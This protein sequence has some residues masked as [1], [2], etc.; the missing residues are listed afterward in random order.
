MDQNNESQ[1]FFER[2]GEYY[3]ASGAPVLQELERRV[4]GVAYGGNSYTTAEQAN[5]LV[6]L[7]NLR[8]GVQLLDVGSGAGWPGTFLAH[9][10]GCRV[11]LTDMPIEGLIAGRD[12]AEAEDIDV[13]VA[14]ASGV[15][16]PFRAHSFDAI[17]HSDVLC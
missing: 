15:S 4:L 1:E 3:A 7:L 9:Q 8:Q 16:L 5:E 6:M 14:A 10:S 13:R 11:V 17:T 12:R 2:F